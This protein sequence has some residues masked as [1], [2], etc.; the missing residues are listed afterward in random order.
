M[1][2]NCFNS[3]IFLF[4]MLLTYQDQISS[5]SGLQKEEKRLHFYAK[6]DKIPLISQGVW[7]VT[8]GVVQLGNFDHTG[9]EILLGWAKPFHFFGLWFT[10]LETYQVY[11]LSDVYLKWYEFTEIETNASLSSLI[12]NQTVMK[13]KQTENLLAIAGIKRVEHRLIELLKL[14]KTD[15]GEVVNSGIR[16][17]VRFTHE[18]LAKIIGTTR[19]TVTRILRNFNV[20]DSLVLMAIA[21]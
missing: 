12:L 11:A 7:Q 21:I 2:R 13:L 18:N 14:L 3:L 20:K 15:L 9:E 8:K 19:V 5:L 10:N 16:I 4:P 1:N 17:S 6:G